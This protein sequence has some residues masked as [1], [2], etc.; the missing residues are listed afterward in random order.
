MNDDGVTTELY[1]RRGDTP[2]IYT[3]WQYLGLYH[4]PYTTSAESLPTSGSQ[5]VLYGFDSLDSTAT[6][7]STT[8]PNNWFMSTYVNLNGALGYTTDSSDV[9]SYFF[10]GLISQI[11]VHDSVP[12]TNEINSRQ[13]VLDYLDWY[14]YYWDFTDEDSREYVNQNFASKGYTYEGK[15]YTNISPDLIITI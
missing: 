12:S 7:T 13:D 11:T 3:G 1:W 5:N 15:F 6:L 9:K 10:I 14:E 2:E 8:M 4:Q